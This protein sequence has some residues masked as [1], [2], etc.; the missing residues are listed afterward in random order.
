L[1]ISALAAGEYF[2]QIENSNLKV[3]RKITKF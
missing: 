3:R 2:L 1:D